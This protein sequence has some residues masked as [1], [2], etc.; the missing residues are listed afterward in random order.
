MHHRCCQI[1]FMPLK[2]LLMERGVAKEDV[3]KCANK[4]NLMIL[5]KQRADELKI[6]WVEEAVAVS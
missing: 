6:E 5:A 2:R 3:N 4:F 1:G